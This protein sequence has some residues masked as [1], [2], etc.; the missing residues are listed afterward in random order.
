MNVQRTKKSQNSLEEHNEKENFYQIPRF[1][2][3]LLQK[4]R[5]CDI[6]TKRQKEQIL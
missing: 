2:I 1:I 3:K 5:Q 6:S 4:L